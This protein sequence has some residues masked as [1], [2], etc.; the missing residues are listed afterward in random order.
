MKES[1]P[2]VITTRKAGGRKPAGGPAPASRGRLLPG[3][4][5]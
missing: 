1:P 3:I 5:R 4:H 2:K